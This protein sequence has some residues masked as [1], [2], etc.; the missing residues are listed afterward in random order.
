MQDTAA[1]GCPLKEKIG[2]LRIL[3]TIITDSALTE[4]T[5]EEGV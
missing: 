5:R 4:E 2:V 3:T 1:V